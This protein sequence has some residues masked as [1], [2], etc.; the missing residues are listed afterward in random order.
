MMKILCLCDSPTL[1]SGFARVAQNLFKR[2]ARS[3]AKIDV[4]GIAFMGWG[5][6]NVPYINEL[7]PAGVSGQWNH[8]DHLRV[9]LQQLRTGGYT[10]VWLMQD[11]FLL[12]LHDFPKALKDVCK[13][14]GIR[15]MLYYPVDAPLK[16]EWTDIIAAVDVAV[17]YT[18]YG[19]LETQ[20]AY[21]RRVQ[22]LRAADRT[23]L[24]AAALAAGQPV[25]PAEVEEPDELAIEI[26][27]HGV[28]T[29]V[30][31]P[32]GDRERTRETFWVKPWLKPGDFLMLNVNSHQRR[33]DVT[34]SLE[35]LAELKALGVPAK[36]VMHMSALSDIDVNLE[37]VGEQ[38]GL[39]LYEDW[40]HHSQLFHLG[41]GS[42]PETAP[43]GQPSLVQLYNLADLYLTTTRGEGWGLGI[44]E[45]LACG[46]PVA[47]PGHTACG[48]L[49]EMF[50]C[51]GQSNRYVCLPA[52]G[53][54]D[55]LEGDNSRCRPRVNLREAGQRI[56]DYYE[57]GSW[58]QRE[59]LNPFLTNEFSWD[60]IAREMLHRLKSPKPTTAPETIAD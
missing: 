46:T 56:K 29:A 36:L 8:P 12:S 57:M 53:G 6:K 19:M 11:T 51:A 52:E 45:A 32:L 17:A 31:R 26:L 42:L 5:Y 27:P 16:P 55:V 9:F 50:A 28:D 22:Q 41:Q 14:K 58:R 35:I 47:M 21:A 43:V 1:T 30:Y 54:C 44:T 24:I 38:L 23:K 48:D 2:W 18:E 60:R 10:H 37:A 39:T 49:M 34:R 3:G 59:V 13:E 40:V 20:R 4:W 7:F 33:K 15:S 25:P